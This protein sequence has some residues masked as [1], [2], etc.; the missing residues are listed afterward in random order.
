MWRVKLF[1]VVLALLLQKAALSLKGR[2]AVAFVNVRKEKKFEVSVSYDRIVPACDVCGR[3]AEVE[4]QKR[5][6]LHSMRDGSSGE[7]KLDYEPVVNV[8][9]WARIR[10]EQKEDGSFNEKHACP[11]C[12]SD[13][14]EKI[15]TKEVSAH[16]AP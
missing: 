11:A 4:I 9:G 10:L 2:C 12:C 13:L 16:V 6:D 15:R 3:E 1:F 7:S 14:M 8:S 5:L